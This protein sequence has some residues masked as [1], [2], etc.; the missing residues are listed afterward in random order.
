[1]QRKMSGGGFSSKRLPAGKSRMDLNVFIF[2][3]IETQRSVLFSSTSNEKV[4]P[5]Q[6]MDQAG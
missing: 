3:G 6:Q 4:Q 5:I 1:M 2:F